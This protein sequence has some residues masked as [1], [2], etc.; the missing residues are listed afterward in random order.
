MNI[1]RSR[2]ARWMVAALFFGGIAAVGLAAH[3][4]APALSAGPMLQNATPDG[5]TVVWWR[6]GHGPAELRVRGSADAETTFP[7]RRT[8]DRFEARAADL[9]PGATYRYEILGV[10]PDGSRRRLAV[11]QA[12]TAPPPGTPFSF[13]M[14]ADSGSGKRP[15]YRLAQVMERYPLDLVLHGGD[16]I[17]GQAAPGDYAD[18]FFR[19][20]RNLLRDVPFYP[21]LGNHDLKED[22]GQAF[23][24][25]FS[26][27]ANGPA[28]LPPNHCFWFD[29][30]DARFVG[31]DSNLDPRTLADAVVPWLRDALGSA[32]RRWK[33]VFF[34]H[35]P[36]AG[37]NRPADG[38]VCDILVPA[39]EA[40]GADVVFCGHN[41][42]YERMLPRRNGRVVPA[43]EGILYVVSGAG[44]KSLH[45][46]Q[47]E[48]VRDLAKFDD[49]QFSFTWVRVDAR[50]VAIEQIG[51]NDAVLDRVELKHLDSPGPK[52]IP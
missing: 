38:K 47:P 20:Y 49:S 32:G 39:I 12:R 6:S 18:K 28:A 10:D 15:Q 3:W 31:I 4:T 22:A 44:G 2:P 48:A 51:A 5:F 27:P 23:L 21:V 35:A 8:G 19:P 13:L 17:Y 26:L 46:E 7:A 50:R 41:H 1:P 37:G 30:G 36:W 33:F 42:L 25:T 11:G 29:Y 52:D 43:S 14:F 40:G 24:D 34:H 16:L 9:E 45:K